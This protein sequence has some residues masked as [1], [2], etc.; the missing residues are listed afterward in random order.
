[1]NVLARNALTPDDTRLWSPSLV[2]ALPSRLPPLDPVAQLMAEEHRE[3]ALLRLVLSAAGA[4]L[5]L[6]V[7]AGV[8]F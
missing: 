4:I 5:I 8:L 1:M 3:R 6:A 7:G 2:E